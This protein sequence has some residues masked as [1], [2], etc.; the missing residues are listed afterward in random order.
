MERKKHTTLR[1][2][3]TY[4]CD[5]YLTKGEKE[6]QLDNGWCVYSSQKIL[7]LDSE[8]YIEDY[9]D[10]DDDNEV[11]DE[12]ITLNDMN[13]KYRDEIV[14]DVV[15]AC[16]TQKRDATYDEIMKALDYYEKF[17]DFMIL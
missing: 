2:I 12:Y 8:C 1:E 4:I 6:V 3:F 11:F 10:Y 7:T 17:D 5:I 13:L 14:Q 15:I 16:L 9:P